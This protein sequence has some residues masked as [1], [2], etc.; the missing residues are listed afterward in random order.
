MRIPLRSKLTDPF[1]LQ[2]SLADQSI[3]QARLLLVAYGMP[4]FRYSDSLAD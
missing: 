4:K 1:G 3:G 2:T